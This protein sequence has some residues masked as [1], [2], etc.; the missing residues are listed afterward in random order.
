MG[1]R[2]WSSTDC[3]GTVAGGI[4]AATQSGRRASLE[5]I[6]RVTGERA[7]AG[8]QRTG[9]LRGKDLPELRAEIRLHVRRA[10][11][12]RRVARAENFLLGIKRGDVLDPRQCD[13]WIE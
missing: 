8:R 5:A 3:A 13:R 7:Y 9:R 4:T 11:E 10:G 12:Q 1:G 6:R 2:I